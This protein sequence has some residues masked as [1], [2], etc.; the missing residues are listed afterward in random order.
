MPHRSLP[1]PDPSPPAF[2]DPPWSSLRRALDLAPGS[3]PRVLLAVG[4]AVGLGAVG[5]WFLRPAGPPSE[6]SLPIASAAPA[7]SQPEAS[8][9]GSAT[10]VTSSTTAPTGQLVVQAAGQ[11]A[12]PGVYDLPADSRVVD[13]VDEAGGLTREA[14]RERV[15]LAAPLVDGERVWFP[16]VGQDRPPDVV[17]GSGGGASGGA[18]SDGAGGSAAPS[19]SSPVDLNSASAEDLDALPGVGPATAAAILA[20]REQNGSFA[21]VEELLEV[22]GIGEA[23]LEQLRPLVRV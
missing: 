20:Y 8:V 5:W 14:D 16:A 1:Q 10:D 12:H 7:G 4:L 19:P 18:G 17:A 9:G 22:R 2:G 11:V 13:L 3:A 6:G 15:N 21:S 23:K